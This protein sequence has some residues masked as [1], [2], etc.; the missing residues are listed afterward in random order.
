MAE[1][2]EHLVSKE[3]ISFILRIDKY[4]CI[5]VKKLPKGIDGG[6]G[7][8][9]GAPIS[10]GGGGGGGGIVPIVGGGGGGGGP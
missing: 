1:E 4:V 5:H 3:I 8:G 9:G 6:G 2:E 10:A 7:G